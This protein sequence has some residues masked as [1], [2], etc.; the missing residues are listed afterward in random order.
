MSEFRSLRNDLQE[1]L[2][3]LKN[4]LTKIEG[5]LQRRPHPDSTERATERANDEVLE[6]LSTQ[7]RE[8][9]AQIEVAL[10][11]IDAGTYGQCEKCGTKIDPKRLQA[12]PYAL[13]CIACAS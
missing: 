5:D 6:H 13:R 2:G 11:R 3:V 10:A 12:L 4:R 8:E 9:V 7:E 1:R